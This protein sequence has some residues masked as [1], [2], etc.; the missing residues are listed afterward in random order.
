[1]RHLNNE[2]A[3]TLLEMLI[4]LACSLVVFVL[5]VPV[6]HVMD[7][8]REVKLNPLEWEVFYQQTKLEVKEAKE[9]QVTDSVLTMKTLNDQLVSFEIYQDKLRRRVNGTGHE[10]L[11]QNIK[12]LIFTPKENGFQLSVVDLSGK[13]YSKTFFTYSEIPVNG[14]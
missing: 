4:A 14:L 12:S 9:I 13:S 1:M 5:I 8:K 10:I 7:S 3:F 2:M 11:L 6:L